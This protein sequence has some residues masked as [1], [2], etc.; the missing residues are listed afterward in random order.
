MTDV[1]NWPLIRSEYEAGV[2]LS[3]LERRHPVSRQGIAKH[4]NSEGWLQDKPEDVETRL[5]SKCLGVDCPETRAVLI[6]YLGAG[7][8]AHTACKAVGI[9]TA[10]LD[11]WKDGDPAFARVIDAA[12]PGAIAEKMSRVNAAGK[13]GQ[14]KFD[15]WYLEHANAARDEF[16]GQPGSGGQSINVIINVERHKGPIIVDG[17]V[18][19]E[20]Y[21]GE[22]TE[23]EPGRTVV[24]VPV[25]NPVQ[26]IAD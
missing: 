15:T 2:T 19:D 26:E 10:D 11:H 1:L 9:T 22:A 23:Q 6:G 21:E 16:G 18:I 12:I 17:K 13:L 24:K 7:V 20:G 14:A 3:E 4:R 8:P 5:P 25:I